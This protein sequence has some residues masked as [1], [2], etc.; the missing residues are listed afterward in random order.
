MAGASYSVILS[1]PYGVRLA[2][3]NT[4][5]SLTYARKVNDWS[6]ATL[7]L[8]GT[9]DT[10][11]ILVDG[12]LEIW[13][14]IAG[15]PAYLDTETTWLIQKWTKQW[16]SKGERTIAIE[17]DHPLVL[18]REPGRFVDA[19]A[20]ASGASKSGTADDVMKA[21]VRECIGTSAS[22]SRTL[23]DLISV[24]ADISQA[25]S[26]SRAFAWRAVLNVLQD[27]ANDSA[28]QGTYC[29]FDIVAPAPDGYEFRTYTGQR[30][31]DHRFPTGLSPVL[32]DPDAGSV[33]EAELELDYR[34]EVTFAKAGGQGEGTARTIGSYQ[35]PTRTGVSPFRW[36]EVFADAT[37]TADTTVLTGVARA[38]VRASRPRKRFRGKLISTT[39]AQYGV[40]WGWGDL[41]T[42][43][44]EG[45]LFDCR[46]DAVSV[47]V[48]AGG[49]Y[50]TIEAYLR[51]DQ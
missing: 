13:R 7:V 14:Q 27:L 6:T 39:D 49:E 36:R 47:T 37:Q 16:G 4:F 29:A 12:R 22:S 9:F 34:D 15:T 44:A 43:Q 10:S 30:G 50:E 8:P 20:G 5:S 28:Q 41:V 3:A 18:L 38:Q 46:V 17:A 24:A 2:E 45:D 19:Y 11:N 25:A 33:G 40:H 26:I 48:K 21:I 42:V 51:N 1:D 31:V 32:L 23:S 35:D